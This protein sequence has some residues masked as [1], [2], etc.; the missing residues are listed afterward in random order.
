MKESTF[1]A[2]WTGYADASD[3]YGYPLWVAIR[4]AEPDWLEQDVAMLA[5]LSVD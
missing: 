1:I 4:D 3:A 2:Y 5:A